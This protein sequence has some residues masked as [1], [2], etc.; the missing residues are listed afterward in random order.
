MNHTHHSG[1]HFVGFADKFENLYHWHFIA[2][3]FVEFPLVVQQVQDKVDVGVVHQQSALGDILGATV[4]VMHHQQHRR[5][6]SCKT[7]ID[8]AESVRNKAAPNE[9][10][11][12]SF[13]FISRTRAHRKHLAGGSKT[14]KVLLLENWGSLVW[15]YNLRPHRVV[16]NSNP[17]REPQ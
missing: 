13:G 4:G 14:L 15:T 10:L 8:T 2:V 9:T 17:D 16:S 5:F 3:A 11:P 6:T 7:R 1:I 12:K